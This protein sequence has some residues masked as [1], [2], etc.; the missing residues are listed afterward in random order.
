M[1]R[2]FSKKQNGA[3]IIEYTLLA[4]F[5][6]VLSVVGIRALGVNLSSIN[7]QTANVTANA[8]S[9]AKIA[10]SKAKANYTAGATVQ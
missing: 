5:I 2:N 9:N 10:A 4:A 3:T 1:K 8:Q 6:I 7:V